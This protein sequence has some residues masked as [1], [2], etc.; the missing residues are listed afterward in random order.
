MKKTN[1]WSEQIRTKKN[2][3][4]TYLRVG[5]NKDYFEYKTRRIKVKEMMR[6]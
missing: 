1:W 5:T 3:L 6:K 2:K 4:K